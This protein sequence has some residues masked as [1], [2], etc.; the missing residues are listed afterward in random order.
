MSIFARRS[1]SPKKGID[2]SGWPAFAR[3]F[4]AAL[5]RY[6]EDGCT[7]HAAALAFFGIFSV[8]PFLLVAVPIVNLFSDNSKLPLQDVIGYKVGDVGASGWIGFAVLVWAASGASTALVSSFGRI[9]QN[10]ERVEVWWRRSIFERLIGISLVFAGGLVLATFSITALVISVT[11]GE[12]QGWVAK[13]LDFLSTWALAALVMAGIFRW[14]PY[15]FDLRWRSAMLG[16]AVGGFFSAVL[17]S[18]YATL[19]RTMGIGDVFAAA[20]SLVLL[21]MF[22]YLAAL[23]LFLG[24]EVAKAADEEA[25][26]KTLN[27]SS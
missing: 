13:M 18:V 22:I 12:L 17:K 16:G 23:T 6:G 19:V 24:A 3:V 26:A 5:L 25:R 21:M 8:G 14:V 27:G 1:Q 4:W 2:T 20:S 9:F 7:R 15:H 10:T 11:T